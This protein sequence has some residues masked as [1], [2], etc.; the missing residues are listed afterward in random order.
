MSTEPLIPSPRDPWLGDDVRFEEV[1]TLIDEKAWQ[2][3]G[4]AGQDFRLRWYSGAYR[5]DTRPE[6]QA[7]DRLMRTG[8]WLLFT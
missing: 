1:D 2:Y 8:E 6:V 5:G 7:L 3:L 4:I